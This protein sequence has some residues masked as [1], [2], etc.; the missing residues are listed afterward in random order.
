MARYME[1]ADDLRKEVESFVEGNLLQLHPGLEDG[2]P[3]GRDSELI[4]QMVCQIGHMINL[5][6]RACPRGVQHTVRLN[7]V[8]EA[9]GRY[10]KV[11][12]TEETDERTGRSYHKIHISPRS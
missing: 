8:R 10:C 7:I 9:V 3:C 5:A 1:T 4:N 2:D 12:M 11:T 6:I